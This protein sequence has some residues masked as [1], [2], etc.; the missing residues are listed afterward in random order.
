MKSDPALVVF[1]DLIREVLGLSPIV[2]EGRAT[3]VER[4]GA[5]FPEV[6]G[7][8]DVTGRRKLPPVAR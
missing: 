7:P 2:G 4:F 5:T 3:N 1:R 8:Y 6:D